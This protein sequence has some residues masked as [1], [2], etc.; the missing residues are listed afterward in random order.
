MQ[1]RGA[2]MQAP[3]WVR[4]RL[5]NWG[6][7]MSERG[8][9]STGYPRTN[10]LAMQRGSAASVD[11]VPVDGVAAQHT[12]R[13]VALLQQGDERAWMAIHC[14]YVGSPMV[15]GSRRR[16]LTMREMADVLQVSEPTA[17]AWTLTGEL[18]VAATLDRWQMRPA[19]G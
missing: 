9:C 14:R 18:E 6:R 16:P 2:A 1:P 15:R 7:W 10:M 12:H 11:V 3:E 4:E 5:D 13:A 19:I 8:S 17:R